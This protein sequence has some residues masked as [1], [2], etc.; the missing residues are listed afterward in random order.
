M[1]NPRPQNHDR[2]LRTCRPCGRVTEQICSY[3]DAR[4]YNWLCLVC[5]VPHVKPTLTQE[6]R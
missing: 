1:K 6:V 3:V 4:R 5:Q 2:R